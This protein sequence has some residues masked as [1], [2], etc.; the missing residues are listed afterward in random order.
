MAKEA[1][2]VEI[3]ATQ[4]LRPMLEEAHS[5][6]RPRAGVEMSVSNTAAN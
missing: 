5:R 2:E 1:W 4:P 3:K 6:R